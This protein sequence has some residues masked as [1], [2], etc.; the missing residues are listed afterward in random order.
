MSVPFPT[1]S[2]NAP[3]PGSF[4]EMNA[5]DP[6]IRSQMEDGTVLSRARFTVNKRRWEFVYDNLTE[7]DK[8]LLDTLENDTMVG[9]ETITWTHP[10]TDVSYTVRLAEPIRFNVQLTNKDLWEAFFIFIE[11]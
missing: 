8:T 5:Y 1:L 9:A 6:S 4:K 7:A 10:K 11:D 2:R 3:R